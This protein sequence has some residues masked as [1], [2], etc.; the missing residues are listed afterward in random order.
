MRNDNAFRVLTYRESGRDKTVS[1]VDDLYT[2]GLITKETRRLF[3]NAG[4]PDYID[5]DM[6]TGE[7][8][9]EEV[10]GPYKNRTV[11]ELIRIR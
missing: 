4:M 10:V 11:G 3:R 6:E 8:L 9:L 2:F 1:I 7:L 5:L